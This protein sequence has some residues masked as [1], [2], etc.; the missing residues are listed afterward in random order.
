[1]TLV[2]FL[3]TRIGGSVRRAWF[4]DE[5]GTYFRNCPLIDREIAR[6]ISPRRRRA[7]REEWWQTFRE[8]VT[9]ADAIGPH[10][11]IAE[12]IPFREAYPDHPGLW[13]LDDA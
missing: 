4:Q 7:L 6:S 10:D 8:G 3:R 13:R 11:R 12:A 5:D 2:E 1:M 9:R